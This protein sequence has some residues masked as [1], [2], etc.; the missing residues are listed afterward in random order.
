MLI[1]FLFSLFF[2]FIP[3]KA[4]SQPCEVAFSTSMDFAMV[5]SFNSKSEKANWIALIEKYNPQFDLQ[6]KREGYSREGFHIIINSHNQSLIFLYNF[7]KGN[8]YG[9]NSFFV[10]TIEGYP[11]RS[12][13]PL[14]GRIIRKVSQKRAMVEI[15][16]VSGDLKQIEVE[17]ESAFKFDYYNEGTSDAFGDGFKVFIKNNEFNMSIKQGSPNLG[18]VFEALRSNRKKISAPLLRVPSRTNEEK[19]F[20]ERGFST[21]YVRGI[22]EVNEWIGVV[23]Q[24]RK[25]KVNPYKTH[26][27]YFADKVKA[28]V[29]YIREGLPDSELLA[30]RALER[31]EK[32]AD[33]TIQQEGVTYDW[34]LRFNYALS[35]IYDL[36][37]DTENI[38]KEVYGPTKVNIHNLVNRFPAYII[39]P[40]IIGKMGV[41]AINRANIEDIYIGGLI[42]KA[43]GGHGKQLVSPGWFLNHDIGTHAVKSINVKSTYF[44]KGYETF[45]EKLV[46]RIQRLPTEK[47][48][49]AELAFFILMHEAGGRAFVKMSLLDIG[50][51]IH[52]TLES[53][54]LAEFN[55]RGLIDTPPSELRQVHEKVKVISDDFMKIFKEARGPR[56]EY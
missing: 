28:H 16:T 34:W 1:S 5:R 37:K 17:I 13:E 15:V 22:D 38:I 19:R 27:D 46:E 9:R 53:Q 49:N 11:T 55:F 21:A 26:I 2:L 31:L 18:M 54:M 52:A 56:L 14:I 25:L 3:L 20:K 39:M 45:Y 42:N 40:T 32:H 36:T 7:Y 43:E 41:V 4:I 24:I 44:N 50:T 48:K 10:G 33:R 35:R 29:E 8:I 6:L 51:S 47:R 23:R 12:S 30:I